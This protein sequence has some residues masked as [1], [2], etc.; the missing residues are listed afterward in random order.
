MLQH[1]ADDV[2]KQN[3]KKQVMTDAQI[4]SLRRSLQKIA[5]TFESLA[6]FMAEKS[7][8]VPVLTSFPINMDEVRGWKSELKA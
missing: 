4:N 8:K 7:A 3:D 2:S 1:L 5:D 6:T